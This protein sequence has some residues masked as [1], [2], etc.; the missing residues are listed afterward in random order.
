MGIG[1]SSP[2][3]RLHV[4][5]AIVSTEKVLASGS[6]IDAS[7]ANQW[8]LQSVGDQSLQSTT[9]SLAVNIEL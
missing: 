6:T 5:G 3:A 4:D 8:V 7:Q 9:W 2:A 1:N